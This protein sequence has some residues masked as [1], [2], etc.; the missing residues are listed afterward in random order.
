MFFSHA[1]CLPD[2]SEGDRRH[3][4]DARH[5]FFSALFFFLFSPLR[6]VFSL[7]SPEAFFA[8][9]LRQD[10]FLSLRRSFAG[11]GGAKGEGW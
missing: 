4:F 9:L 8:L 10:T 1:V 7:D 2:L 11:W 5:L 3:I 6:F